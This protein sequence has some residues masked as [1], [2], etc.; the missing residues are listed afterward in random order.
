MLSVAV[1]AVGPFRRHLI[2]HYEYPADRYARTRDGAPIVTILFGITEGTRA[3]T[4]V[5]SALGIS[6]VWDFNQHKIDVRKV[7]FPKLESTLLSLHDHAEY[8]FDLA[9]LRAF[10]AEGYELYFIPN[11]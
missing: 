3:G 6:D 10:V 4:E 2:E 8:E 7:D 1:L 11:G 5:A 9:A